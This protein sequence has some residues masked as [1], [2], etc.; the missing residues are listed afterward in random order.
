MRGNCLFIGLRTVLAIFTVTLFVT[1]TW[2]AT[3]TVLHSFVPEFKDGHNPGAS[4]TFDAAGNLYGT[5]SA[6]GT[7]GLGTV[8]ELKPQAGGGWMKK[9]LHNFGKGTDGAS[10]YGSLIFDAAGNLYGTTTAG[11]NT[12]CLP[13]CGTVFEL[14]PQPGGK[15]TENVLYS[16]NNNGADGASPEDGLIFDAAGNL[17]G[18]TAFGGTQGGGGTVFEL[19]PQ[20]GGIWTEN[21][22]YSFNNNGTDGAYPAADLIF[23]GAG[24]LYGTT[25]AGGTYGRG[26]VFELMPQAG[27]G[28][29]EN[30]L[31][32]FNNNGTDGAGPQ[33]RLIFDGAGNLYG[34]TVEAG[35]H[36]RRGGTVFELMPQAGGSWT[37]QVLHSF[38]KDGANPGDGLVF[39]GAGHLYG[40]TEQG[41]THNSGAVF[42]LTPQAGGGWAEQ[43]VHSFNGKDGAFPR[44]RLVLDGAGDLYGTTVDGGTYAYGT[45]FELMPR[46]GG[47]WTEHVLHSFDERAQNGGYPGG[48]LVFD[49]AGN[50][51]GTTEQGGTRNS[52]TVFELTPQAGGGWAESMLYSFGTGNDGAYP[53]AGLIFDAAGN[54]YG[55]TSQGGTNGAGTV[56]ELTPQAGGGWTEHVLHNFNGSDGA[57]PYA[58]LI[59]DAVGNLYGTTGAGGTYGR[60]GTVFELTP[61]ASGGWTEQ[62]LHSFGN[63]GDGA[64]PDASLIFDSAGNL[65]GTTEQGG[66]RN[67]GTVFELTPQAGGGWAEQVLNSFGNNGTDERYPEGGLIFDAAGNLYGTTTAGGTYGVGVVFELTPQAGGGWNEQ[68]LHSFGSGTDGTYPASSLIFD[69]D[70]NLYGT[71]GSGGT[72]G[73]G[74]VFELTPTAGGVWAENVLYSFTENGTDGFGPGGTLIFDAAGNLYGTTYYGDTYGGFPGYGTV[75]EITP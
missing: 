53:R 61:Q 57:N 5:T 31:Y 69:A 50:L 63:V 52:G 60:G 73:V 41:G 30:V 38:N 23:D 70:G 14:T 37:E 26:T 39:D 29:T 1:S 20:A 58:S 11:G 3:E 66:T 75:F 15:W 7:Y 55:T 68:L 40:T 9:V 71:T 67:S 27:G 25:G 4:L 62:V 72:Y 48:G 2:A 32:S 51:Y 18:T 22:L 54:L 10:P 56:V 8:F 65:Y 16:F 17:Y 21:V 35:I 13:S 12:G 33:G 6:G 24:N 36:R 74:T 19:M 28:W 42:E 34:T 44:A 43:V 47:G 46:A 45:V 49:A 59:F 64:N